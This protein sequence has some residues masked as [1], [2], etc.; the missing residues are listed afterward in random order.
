MERKITI[1]TEDGSSRTVTFDST[2][3]TLAELKNE[4]NNKGIS[5]TGKSF[6]E[7]ISKT[8]IMTDE[9]ILPSNLPYK[10][11]VT[12]DLVFMLTT[13]NKKINSGADRAELITY[14]KD[15]NLQEEVKERYGKNYTNVKTDLLAELVEEYLS[16]EDAKGETSESVD[17]EVISE[18]IEQAISILTEVKVMLTGSDYVKIDTSDADIDRLLISLSN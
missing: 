15:N 9:S 2:A 7:G 1:I 10:G 14:I 13:P 4:L 8:E 12:N 17:L 16:V 6:Y 11:S 5:Y 18:K 3:E